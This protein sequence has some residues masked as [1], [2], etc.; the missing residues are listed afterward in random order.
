[1]D[2][3]VTSAL[4]KP[5]LSQSS[6]SSDHTIGKAENE[7]FRNNFKS[8]G[9]VLNNV[10]KRFIPLAM[11][12]LGLRVGTS[13]H[14]FKNVPRSWL[15]NQGLLPHVWTVRSLRERRTPE[16]SHYLVRKTDLDCLKAARCT[17][18]R[19]HGLFLRQHLLLVTASLLMMMT[20]HHVIWKD[21]GYV[22][23]TMYTTTLFVLVNQSM[24]KLEAWIDNSF[25]NIVIIGF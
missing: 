17:Y 12:R 3:V 7:K 21:S 24:S 22:N 8:S 13:T 6:I 19:G 25:Y 5:C 11:N 16:D 14:P 18:P 15:W 9:L 20:I 4:Q 23:N 1:M 10:T 2:T